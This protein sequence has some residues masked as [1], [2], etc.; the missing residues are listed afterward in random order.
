[1]VRRRSIFAIV[2]SILVVGTATFGVTAYYDRKN[3]SNYL[4]GIYQKNLY[5]L[6]T[7]VNGLQVS[8]SK[9]M[10]STS[11]RQSVTLFG[12]VWRQASAAQDKISSLPITHNSI[13]ITSKFLTQVSDFSYAMLRSNNSGKNL[14]N[15][16]FGSIEKLRDY[17]GYLT[18]VLRNFEAQLGSREIGWDIGKNMRGSIFNNAEANV[19][20]IFQTMSDQIQNYPT[21][22][23]DGPFSENILNIKPKVLG[24]KQISLSDAKRVALK[25]A[26]KNKVDGITEYS[27]KSGQKIPVYALSLKLKN[28]E[29]STI[30]MDISRNGGHI[31]YMLDPRNIPNAN[32]TL[33]QAVDNGLKFLKS[34][35]YSDLLPIYTLRYDNIAVINYVTVQNKVL[36]YPDQIKLKVALDNGDI[37]G[38]E[39]QKYLTAHYNRNLESPA[40]SET[41]ASKAVSKRLSV[42]NIRLAVIPMD[43]TRE[44]LCYEFFGDFRGEKYFVYINAKNGLEER[45]LKVVNTDNGEQTM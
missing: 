39:S 23:Y 21:L 5:D 12:D 37:V 24:E 27:D 8:L 43:S 1:M 4:R 2:V 16:E 29:D 14:S 19:N 40:V 45:I 13:S 44:V 9:A 18:V 42:K 32:I 17:C 15:T 31:I 41:K 28:R 20:S 36:I 3:F 7:N 34:V 11:T 10:L 35:G 30:D 38:I 25:I 33:K 22:I 6:I 26:G